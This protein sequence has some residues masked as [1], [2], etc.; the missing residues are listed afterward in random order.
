MINTAQGA[1]VSPMQQAIGT[2]IGAMTGI[3][4]LRKL[5]VV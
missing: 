3:A 4:G 2:G 1:S 5:G